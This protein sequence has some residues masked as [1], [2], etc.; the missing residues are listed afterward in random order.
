MA[1]QDFETLRGRVQALGFELFRNVDTDDD[2]RVIAYYV[3][4]PETHRLVFT[5]DEKPAKELADFIEQVEKS[6]P[7]W[8][9]KPAGIAE[10]RARVEALGYRLVTNSAEVESDGETNYVGLYILDPRTNELDIVTA[11]SAEDDVSEIESWC[12]SRESERIIAGETVRIS[13][14][15][16]IGLI[17][18][19]HALCKQFEEDDGLKEVLEAALSKNRELCNALDSVNFGQVP[20]AQGGAQ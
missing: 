16:A 7:W 19:A 3:N 11:G 13:P 10:L 6:G 8:K 5:G 20:A 18:A 12:K 1:T 15:D 17:K 14:E 2:D 9:Q 4:D